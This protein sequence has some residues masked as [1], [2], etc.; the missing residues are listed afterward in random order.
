MKTFLNDRS[1]APAVE[2]EQVRGLQ[3]AD[4]L[5]PRQVR[6]PPVRAELRPPGAAGAVGELPDV[7]SIAVHHVDLP[8]LAPHTN[9]C[10]ASK[11]LRSA[12]GSLLAAVAVGPAAKC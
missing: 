6:Q 3:L 1:R 8:V 10:Y 11:R 5:V 9:T 4:R 2:E 12:R 7:P